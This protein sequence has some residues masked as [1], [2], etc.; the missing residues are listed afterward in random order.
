VKYRL[1]ALD[2]DGTAVRDGQMP[3]PRV[4]A[5]VAQAVAAGAH[6]VIATGRGYASARAWTTAFDLKTPLICYQGALVKE[7][8]GAQETL[9]VAAV[10]EAPLR[11]VIAF[12]EERGLEMTLYSEDTLYHRASAYG[13]DFFALW[14]G[15][16]QRQVTYLADG[17]AAMRAA[18]QAPAK[19]L[20]LGVPA[21]CD[22]LTPEL[23]ARFGDRLTVVRT[24]PLFV[25]VLAPTVSKGR[26]LAFLAERFGVPRAEVIAIGDSGN[27]V[28]ML[29]WAGLGVAMGNAFPAALAA[30]DWVAP[31]VEEDGAAVVIEKFVLNGSVNRDP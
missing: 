15:L 19:A 26:A 31:S 8:V 27:D 3:T 25:E 23:E 9:Y 24:H 1:I 7:V 2:L 16:P 6:V 29:R 14:F 21:A 30:A 11:E 12:A 20:F 10:P 13:E 18:G 28:S 5:A 4:T 17:L 22:V